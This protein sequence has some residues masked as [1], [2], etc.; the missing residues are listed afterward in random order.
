MN[1]GVSWDFLSWLMV[2][3]VVVAAIATRFSPLVKEGFT[4][5]IVVLMGMAIIFKVEAVRR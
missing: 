5:I 4:E 1:R 2:M 3:M